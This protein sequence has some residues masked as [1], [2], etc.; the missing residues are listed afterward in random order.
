ML[1]METIILLLTVV[2]LCTVVAHRFKWPEHILLVL[3]GMGLSLFPG[4]HRIPLDPQLIF[5]VFLPPL[6]YLNAWTT[7]WRDLKDNMRI[8]F[9]MAIGMVVIT[10]L[11]VCA[12][13]HYVLPILPL[14]SAIALGAIVSPPDAVAASAVTAR[15][16]VPRRIVTVLEGESLLNDASALVLLGIAIAAANS[17]TFSIPDAMLRFVLVSLGGVGIGLLVGWGA[18]WIRYRVNDTPVEITLSLLTPF[19]AYIPAE[20]LHVSGVLAC[21]SAGLYVGWKSPRMMSSFTRLESQAV[22]RMVTYII[23]GLIFLLTG[24]QLPVVLEA[25]Q[26]YPPLTLAGYALSVISTVIVIRIVYTYI[27][28]Y[29]PRFLFKP[30]R[31]RDPYPGW[32]N[33][34]IIAWSGMRG[35]ISLAAALA[36]PVTTLSGEAFPG[37]DL[38]IF[39]TFSVILGTLVFQGLTL[40][41]VIRLLKVKDDSCYQCDELEARMR[42]TRGALEKLEHLIAKSDMPHHPDS[43]E[44]VRHHYQARLEHYDSLPSLEALTTTPCHD[45]NRLHLKILDAERETLINLRNKGEIKEEILHAIQHDLD[46]QEIQ[47]HTQA[48]IGTKNPV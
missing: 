42:A 9:Q 48:L 4:L 29:L 2:A 8:M 17:G 21:V 37:R 15:L 7:S 33:V 35:A 12:V 26:N 14:V 19:A 47:L 22:W 10:T 36:L 28:A 1:E 18:S 5:M 32:R 40:P 34:F 46:L 45:R 13:T 16:S 31:D 23:T 11:A 43:I 27:F 38:I 3:T 20:L 41:L 44:A 30:L 39:L 24:L 25:L 6:L